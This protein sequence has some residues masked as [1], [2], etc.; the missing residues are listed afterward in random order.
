MNL[1]PRPAAHT[2]GLA[3]AASRAFLTS[4]AGLAW[5]AMLACSASR[6]AGA[7]PLMASMSRGIQKK[8]RLTTTASSPS[9]RNSLVDGCVG[10]GWRV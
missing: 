10:G 8:P 6:S 2:A 4:V 3:D 9:M 5:C 1:T 7:R